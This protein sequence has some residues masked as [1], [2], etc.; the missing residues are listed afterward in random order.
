MD[1]SATIFKEPVLKPDQ[2]YAKLR[3]QGLNYI[4]QLGS[5]LWTDFN[6]HDPGITILEAL[7]YA[8]TELGYRVS[9]P[10]KDLLATTDG[11]I[12]STQTFYTAKN[13]LTQS[14]LTIDDYR[15]ILI[16]IPNVANAWLLAYASPAQPNTLPMQEVKLFAD[17][18]N[19]VL[20]YQQTEHPINISGLYCVLLDLDNDPQLGDLN[21]GSIDLTV[22]TSSSSQSISLTLNFP[23]W[24]A[25]TDP[26]LFGIDLTHTELIPAAFASF[27][28]PA[29]QNQITIS[30]GTGSFSGTVVL[31]TV[32]SGAA[33]NPGDIQAL[34]TASGSVS[35]I[36]TL[37]QKVFS[38]YLRK[39][40]T[41]KQAVQN[42]TRKLYRHRN[43]CED[44]VCVTTVP[45]EEIAF[46]FDIDLTPD[47]DINTVQAE[48]YLAIDN[49]LDPPVNFYLLQEMLHKK[50][51]VGNPYTIDEIFDGPKLRHGFIDSQELEASKLV[52]V[53]YASQ[54]IHLIMSIEGVVGVRNFLM[55]A[56]DA[57]GPIAGQSG[58]TWCLNIKPG[59]KPVL[60]VEKSK[61]T[62]YKNQ[63]PYLSNSSITDKLF[64]QLLSRQQRNKLTGHAD[65]LP[66]PVGNYFEVDEYSSLQYL[67]PL[68]YGI[69][70][71][72]LPSTVTDARRAEAR[73]LKAYL[74]FYDQLLADFLSQLRNAGNL[75]S[76]ADIT[77]TYYAQFLGGFKDYESIYTQGVS[78]F[79]FRENVLS[80]EDATVATPDQPNGWER[81][82][83]SNE[84]FTDRRNR[85]LDHLMARFAE[86]F[87]EYAFLMYTLDEATQEETQIDPSDLIQS[88]I[89][90]LKEYPRI[91]YNRA[92]A[93]NYCPMDHEFNLQVPELWDT[94]NVSGLEEK[95]CLLA[96]FKD[97]SLSIK[98]FY[99]RFLECIGTGNVS[100][101]IR[102]VQVGTGIQYNYSLTVG[103][104]T[105]NSANF[106]TLA[107]L[108][109]ALGDYLSANNLIIDCSTE[110][111]YL[112]EHLLLRPR[113]DGF[114][115]APICIDKDC[116]TCGEDDPYSFRISLVLPYWPAH[117]NNM[118]FRAYFEK[119]AREES[120]AHCMVKVCWINQVSM[121]Q[122]QLAYFVWIYSIAAYY[123]NRS[124]LNS[125]W[126]TEAT[127]NLIVVL[128]S[129]HSE[130]PVATLHDCDESKDTN[131]VVLGKTILGTINT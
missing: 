24:K 48:V 113:N 78:D 115:L 91:G 5:S 109:T 16:D 108:L 80:N 99:R 124:N 84:T 79:Q 42:A 101:D 70:E 82:Y 53:L 123:A 55:T 36:N 62:F 11:S 67:F 89:E 64:Q 116:T 34:F 112:V 81:L 107:A 85:F 7:C 21:D 122:F 77:Q 39:I 26:G 96:G 22:Y 86:S 100:F 69:G 32:N 119:L 126:F 83:E 60:A 45:Y 47:A 29:D 27:T 97:P 114:N 90:F 61:I 125:A 35:S 12:P 52:S 121:L 130:Y 72:G 104:T 65:D 63:I 95:L 51:E 23:S 30:Y 28:N 40:Q 92:K 118:N 71:A 76:T 41:A 10:M 18:K 88:K 38:L 49:Y 131:P 56:Y 94:K 25:V 59:Y 4:Q 75:F 43:L 106:T 128:Y 31:N 13:I 87:N 9:L 68:T 44:F 129:L 127:N 14:A 33:V 2:D 103:T 58:Q 57:N 15:K 8:I 102:A 66:V 50:D 19:E 3:S 54:I 74:L 73:Q 17:C 110:G 6:E 1:N 117:F 98:S 37:T 93:F 120:P 105:T 20:T 111:M 46:C